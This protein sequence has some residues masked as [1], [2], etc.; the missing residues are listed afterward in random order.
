MNFN[1]QKWHN[2]KTKNKFQKIKQNKKTINLNRN[3]RIS[4]NLKLK[5]DFKASMQWN[6]A[7]VFS[8][9]RKYFDF[10]KI[11]TNGIT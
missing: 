7:K 3:E 11:E 8:W 9:F 4:E 10:W 6:S 2:N 5:T 1:F